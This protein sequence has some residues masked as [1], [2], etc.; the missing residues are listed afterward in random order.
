MKRL[1]IGRSDGRRIAVGVDVQHKCD[2]L[3]RQ[4]SRSVPTATLKE[5]FCDDIMLS[6]RL[7]AKPRTTRLVKT[8][9]KGITAAHRLPDCVTGRMPVNVRNETVPDPP[10]TSE[11]RDG[12]AEVLRK[13]V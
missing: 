7:G 5:H 10:V 12:V 2:K 3:T 11:R 13:P 9:D 4:L 8:V 1:G 6:I